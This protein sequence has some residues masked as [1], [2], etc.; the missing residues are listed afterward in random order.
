MFKKLYNNLLG[1]LREN[2]KFISF[3][4]ILVIVLRYPLPYYVFTSGGIT[5]LNKRFEIENSYEQK[6]SYNLSYVTQIDGNVLTYVLSYIIPSWDL[7]RVDDFQVNS[8]ETFDEMLKRDRLMLTYANQSATLI[9]YKWADKDI[10]IN[11]SKFYIFATYE[12][13]VSNKKISIGDELVKVDGIEINKFANATTAIAN[14]SDPGLQTIQEYIASK[15][16][17]EYVTLE[18]AD[19]DN[20]YTTSVKVN[21]IGGRKMMGIG[22]I[23]ILDL[24]VEPKIEFKFASSESGSSAGLMTTLAIYDALIE[25]DLTHGLKIAGTGTIEI[26]GSVGEIAGIKYKLSGAEKGGAAVFLVPSGSNY[27]EAVKIKKER[28]YKIEIVEIKTF[29]DAI[30]YL[31]NMETEKE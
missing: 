2:Y 28:N 17:G 18:L 29:D 11:D 22:F 24:E 31:K 13:L 5:D 16:V 15:E 21:N 9:A 14:D 26:D 25:E 6:G 1:F 7:S 3:L 27:E 10:K 8:N 12:E 4:I 20:S 30:N 19:G 23:Q